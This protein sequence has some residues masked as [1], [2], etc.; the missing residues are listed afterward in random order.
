MNIS[1]HERGLNKRK[2]TFFRKMPDEQS[3][4]LLEDN[5]SGK[6]TKTKQTHH[7]PARKQ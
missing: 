4:D 2:L 1:D 3:T 6:K 7:K 5:A